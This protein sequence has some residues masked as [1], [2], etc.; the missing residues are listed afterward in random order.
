[1]GKARANGMRRRIDLWFGQSWTSW[2]GSEGSDSPMS[3]ADTYYSDLVAKQEKWAKIWFDKLAAFHRRPDQR[4]C[5]FDADEVIAYLRDHL[6][7]KTPTWKRLKIVESL[8]YYRPHVQER[9]LDDRLPIRSKL[10]E[11]NEREQRSNQLDGSD[12]ADDMTDIVGVIDPSE[13]DVIQNL[14]REIRGKQRALETEW[15]D[16]SK[17]RAFMLDRG[18]QSQAD[19]DSI[20]AAEVEEHLTDLAVDGNVSVSKQD[21]AFYALLLYLFTH[22]LKRDI[23]KIESLRSKRGK[24]IPTVMSIEEVSSVLSHLG[25]VYLLIGQL[26]YGCGMRISEVLRLRMKDFDFDRMLIEVHASKRGKSRFVPFPECV[27]PSIKPWMESRRI[28]H[29]DDLEKR[30]ASVWLLLAG[31]SI[32]KQVPGSPIHIVR[33]TQLQ[34]ASAQRLHLHA[35]VCSPAAQIQQR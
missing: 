10:I 6:R 3:A 1:M 4:I 34:R 29:Q 21:H 28:L 18:L 14:R 2:T 12:L 26:L 30:T 13:P 35:L 15:A 19:F 11:V 31:L 22:V 24:Q 17:V 7:R 20:T 8:M 16:V 33:C 27:I 9:P 25:G 5:S 23:G 32:H